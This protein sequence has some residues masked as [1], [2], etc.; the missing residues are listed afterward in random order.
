MGYLPKMQVVEQRISGYTI[1]RFWTG[2][3]R[4]S[5]GY[6]SSGIDYREFA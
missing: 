3:C 6:E 1:R 2:C 5:D 4:S